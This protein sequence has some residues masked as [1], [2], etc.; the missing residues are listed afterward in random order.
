MNTPL[1]VSSIAASTS[2]DQHKATYYT[3]PDEPLQNPDNQYKQAQINLK[4]DDWQKVFDSLNVV[5]RVA[6]FHKPLLSV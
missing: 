5:K 3:T 4:S 2:A 1:P 6:M